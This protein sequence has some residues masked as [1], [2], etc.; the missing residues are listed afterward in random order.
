[1]EEYFLGGAVLLLTGI[2]LLRAITSSNKY[3]LGENRFHR[4]CRSCGAEQTVHTNPFG[5]GWI[6][7]YSGN[8][9]KCHC[10]RD[11]INFI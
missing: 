8:D 2:I 5:S 4:I 3:L 9:S 10:H 7:I 1:M 11:V 6:E